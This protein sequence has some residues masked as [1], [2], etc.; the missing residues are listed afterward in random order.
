LNAVF[1]IERENV[2]VQDFSSCEELEKWL[3]ENNRVVL[4]DLRRVA[5]KLSSDEMYI[6]I[7]E[8]LLVSGTNEVHKPFILFGYNRETGVFPRKTKVQAWINSLIGFRCF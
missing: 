7:G 3:E 5:V 6:Y 8:I 1:Y 2:R 4:I